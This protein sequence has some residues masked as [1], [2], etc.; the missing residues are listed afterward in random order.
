M[1][2]VTIRSSRLRR[3]LAGAALAAAL[4][5]GGVAVAPV[6]AASAATRAPDAD[7]LLREA[8]R[9][10]VA[11][12]LAFGGGW[13]WRSVI[14]APS[15]NTDRD[16]GTASVLMGLLVA[17][18]STHDARYLT[19][20]RRAGD[21]LLAA[22]RPA[23]SG[24][25]PD[26]VQPGGSVS[27]IA[28]TSFDD[29]AAGIADALWRLYARTGEAR[30]RR[31]AVAG[32]DWLVSVAEPVAGHPAADQC[33]WHWEQPG[34]DSIY[35][36][37]G[38]G[39]AGIAYA[40]DVFAARTGDPVYARYAAAGAAYV[41]SLITRDGAV[42]EHPGEAAYDTGYLNGAAGDAYL[43]LHLYRSTGDARWLAD[44]ERLLGWLART[45]RPQRRGVAWPIMLGDDP[46]RMR[47]TGF[48]EGN[49]GIGWVFLQAHRMTGNADYLHLAERAGDWLLATARRGGGDGL[50]WPEDAGRDLWHTSLDNGAPGIG[51]FLYDLGRRSGHDRYGKA[52]RAARRWI[53][54][55]ARHDRRGVY[56]YENRSR[57]RWRLKADPSWHW[58]TAGIIDFLARLSGGRLDMPGEQPA[59]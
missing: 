24:R 59:L 21:W 55:V 16:V 28:F 44:A 9:S 32:M 36:G 4:L 18:D 33:L 25:W 56:W 54:A 43:F 40:L 46:D 6:C 2:A 41:E 49:A 27:P 47:A 12:H 53:A 5:A 1:D 10:L 19:A 31:G 14:Q 48:E 38:Q 20:A 35:T 7:P 42:P 30:Y 13:A 3:A 34:R 45:A 26:A 50:A 52:A 29:G 11:R 57:G 8:G 51:V 17:Y 23:G 58:G 22:Q 15:C 39:V 37:I